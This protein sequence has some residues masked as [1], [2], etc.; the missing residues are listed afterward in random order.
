[1]PAAFAIPMMNLSGGIDDVRAGA[2]IG[3]VGH[4]RAPIIVLS[5]SVAA[6]RRTSGYRG[7]IGL[8][9]GEF[10]MFGCI[11]YTGHDST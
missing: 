5:C 10:A 11:G 9:A 8:R 3:R 2:M 7:V 1:M 4:S 6:P